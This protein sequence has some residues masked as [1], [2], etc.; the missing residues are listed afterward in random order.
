MAAQA[1]RAVE[2]AASRAGI[3]GSDGVCEEDRYVAA[4][5]RSEASAALRMVRRL[6]AKVRGVPARFR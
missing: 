2:Q 4:G 5:H 1:E 3:E 6:C